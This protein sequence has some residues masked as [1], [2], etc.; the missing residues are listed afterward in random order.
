MRFTG[1]IK[2]GEKDPNKAL[3]HPP[4]PDPSTLTGQ[5]TLAPLTVEPQAT[6]DFSLAAV[7]SQLPLPL[8]YASIRIQY[9]GAPGSM[10]AQ[11]SSVDGRQDL[12]VDAKTMNEG[13]GWAGSGA[14]PWHMDG[15]TQSILFLSDESDQPAHIGFSVT[16]GG[17]HY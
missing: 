10:I 15:S 13:D 17:V 11:V 8:P 1:V 3:N 12:V 7:M 6:V 16:A 14:N 9:S 4:N 5:L 2:K